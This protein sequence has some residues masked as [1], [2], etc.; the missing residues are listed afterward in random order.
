MGK[1]TV[2]KILKEV[3]ESLYT[4]LATHKWKQISSEFLELWNMP[5][6]IVAINGKY[7][8][9][10]CPKNT[11]SLYRNYKEFFSLLLLAVCDAKYK[12]IFISVRQYGSTNDS[13]VLKNSELVRRLESCSLNIPSEDIAEKYYFKD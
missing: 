13:A 9:M 8:A 5:H 12:Y 7:V 11:G 2:S 3:F 4:V 1:S 6:V 10:E